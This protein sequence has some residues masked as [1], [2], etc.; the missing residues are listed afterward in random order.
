MGTGLAPHQIK[1]TSIWMSLLFGA[2]GKAHCH[3][4]PYFPVCLGTG[5]GVLS[6]ALSQNTVT[7]VLPP[8]VQ[9]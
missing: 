8:L 7:R 4:Q 1:E 5:D 9:V 6:A 2:K 3:I